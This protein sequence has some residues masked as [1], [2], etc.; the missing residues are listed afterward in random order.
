MMG[1]LPMHSNELCTQDRVCMRKQVLAIQISWP[2]MFSDVFKVP[3][4]QSPPFLFFVFFTLCVPCDLPAHFI[5][6]YQRMFLLLL[7]MVCLCHFSFFWDTLTFT[8][9]HIRTHTRTH[10]R[11]LMNNKLEK[12]GMQPLTPHSPT[13]PRS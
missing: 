4:L 3:Q 12:M 1:E 11:L 8:R 5:I 13:S 10:N 9:T 6:S 2:G 7:L